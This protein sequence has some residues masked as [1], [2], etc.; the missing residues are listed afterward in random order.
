MAETP[1]LTSFEITHGI[2]A[3]CETRLLGGENLHAEYEQVRGFYARIFRAASEGDEST[4]AEIA[5]QGLALG[6]TTAELLVG[7]IQ[8][9]CRPMVNTEIGAS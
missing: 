6:Y 5:G 9:G 2:C 8:C 7:M 3:P 1:P 4:C